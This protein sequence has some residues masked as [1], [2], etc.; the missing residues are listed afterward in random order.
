MVQPDDDANKWLNCRAPCKG[1]DPIEA[2]SALICRVAGESEIKT[3]FESKLVRWPQPPKP[4]RK[5]Q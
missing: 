2:A 4:P 1:H 5:K 3:T